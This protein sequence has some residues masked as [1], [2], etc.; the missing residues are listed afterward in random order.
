[1]E[2]WRESTVNVTLYWPYA[3]AAAALLVALGL[4][5]GWYVRRATWWCP[6]CGHGLTCTFCM[7][8]SIPGRAR[9]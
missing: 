3:L 9:A 6:H 5:V 1:M 8:Q 4:T 2:R 7:G